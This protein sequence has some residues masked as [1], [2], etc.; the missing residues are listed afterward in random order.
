[1]ANRLVSRVLLRAWS[2]GSR[3]RYPRHFGLSAPVQN[4]DSEKGIAPRD[5]SFLDIF[6]RSKFA[7]MLDP[8]GQVVD[9][10]VLAVVGDN[11]Y[12]DFGCKFHAVVPVPSTDDGSPSYEKGSKVAVRVLDLE[13]TDHFVG[14]HRDTS[15][16]EAQ[17]ELVKV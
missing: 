1:M 10:E 14:D 12:V 3:K 7:T 8:V 16:L 2:W 6:R 4:E 11:M 17:A 13:M 9:A 15:L 5:E